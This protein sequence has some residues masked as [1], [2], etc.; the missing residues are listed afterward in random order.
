[1]AK[2]NTGQSFADGDTVT[3]AKLNNITSQLNIYTGVISEQAAMS[4]TVST[5]DQ[6]LIADTDNGDSG[7]AN[8]ITVQKL[9]DDSLTNGTYTAANLSGTITS[10]RTVATSATITTG[11]IPN[12]TS[13]T[14]NITL[15]TIPTLTAGTTT[16]TAENVTR[17]TIQT[18]TASTATITT[19]TV[20]TL[21]STTGTITNLSTTLAGDF[22]ISQ[23]TGTL[24]TTGA[25]LGTYGGATSVP[26]LAI[27]AKGQVTSTGTAAIT[28]GLTGFRNRIINGDMRID[29]RN[30][31]ASQ[32]FTASA[33]LAYSVDRFYGYCTGANATGQRVAGTAPNEFVYRF[34]G[35]ASVTAI[36][37]GTRLE[38]TNT[39]DLAGS[40]AT[41]SVQLANSLL[42][43]VTWT[44]YYATTADAFGTLASPTRTQIATGTFTVTSTL[45]TYS[46]QISVPS[47]A[48]TGIEIVFTVG[49]QTSGTW[50]IDNIQLEAGSTATDFERRPYGTELALCQRYYQKS[51]DIGTAPATATSIGLYNFGTA[52]SGSSS[53]GG[54]IRFV[55]PMR[56]SPTVT[57]YDGAGTSG[58]MSTMANNGTTFTNNR[59]PMGS[60]DN[61]GT[62]GFVLAGQADAGNV[63]NCLHYIATSE[64]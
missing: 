31:G 6:L 33:A 48:T 27:N 44:A 46:A 49:A 14:A 20:A 64:L 62:T 34:T 41:L 19:G 53:G 18:L 60:P 40:T 29:Q 54:G 45:T 26:V 28:S 15:G 58:K 22:T 25:T 24:G 21:N 32:T 51:Y 2:F 47:A 4:A 56:S 17:G 43:T 8:R 12:L 63:T 7:A 38:A 10:N 23:G 11:T 16:S 30:A 35:A 42:T 37:F 3:G 5:A 36:G 57:I 13:S 9:L 1:M 39:T 61:I 52:I 50:T 55:L 59:S